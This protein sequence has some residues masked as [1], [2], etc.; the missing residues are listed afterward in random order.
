[1]VLP[2]LLL[3]AFFSTIAGQ[4]NIFVLTTGNNSAFIQLQLPLTTDGTILNTIFNKTQ[5]SVVQ[6][7]RT[8]PQTGVV[9][10]L[11]KIGLRLGQGFF[12]TEKD[13]LLLIVMWLVTLKSLM[14]HS[15]MET[16][17]EQMLLR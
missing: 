2:L 7:T 5:D 8:V 9:I 10:R 17:Q 15:Q 13:I 4:R 1:M 6:I 3:L 11:K 12:L 16:D 14:L